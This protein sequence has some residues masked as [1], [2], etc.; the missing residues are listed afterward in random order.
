MLRKPALSTAHCPRKAATQRGV[1]MPAFNSG[2]ARAATQAAR[3]SAARCGATAINA[4]PRRLGGGLSARTT[5]AAATEGS[6]EDCRNSVANAVKAPDMAG[7]NRV[8]E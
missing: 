4:A 1:V 3:L 5:T 6:D 2:P 8:L 7:S